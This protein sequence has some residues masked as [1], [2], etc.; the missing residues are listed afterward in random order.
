MAGRA[1]RHAIPFTRDAIDRA[2]VHCNERSR[3]TADEQSHTLTTH[4][5]DAF[6][7]CI[8]FAERPRPSAVRA[9]DLHLVTAER[10]RRRIREAMVLALCQRRRR[11]I[12]H[13][14]GI[15][16]GR[17]SQS[18]RRREGEVFH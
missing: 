18:G 8:A 15:R 2:R 3:W 11:E 7:A 5:G 16:F 1:L 14:A 6:R 4:A 10:G 12:Q 17:R 13:R 9:V